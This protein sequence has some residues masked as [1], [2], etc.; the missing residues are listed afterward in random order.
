MAHHLASFRTGWE[1]ETLARY[2]LSRFSFVAHPASV[3][4]DIGTDFFC[5]L[6]ETRTHGRRR[7]LIPRNSFAIQIKSSSRRFDATNKYDYLVGLEM[8]FFVGAVDRRALRL[9]IYSGEYIPDLFS[10]KPPPNR[11][12]IEPC[13]SAVVDGVGAYFTD[14]GH[15]NYILKFPMVI[16]VSANATA[17]DVARIAPALHERCSVMRNNIASWHNDEYIF[18]H[19]HSGQI[20]TYAGCGSARVF[21]RNF[22]DR[23]AEVFA[24]LKWLYEKQPTSFSWEEFEV[25]EMLYCM[26]QQ[27]DNLPNHLA[28][29]FDA[30]NELVANDPYPQC[31]PDGEGGASVLL[32]PGERSKVRSYFALQPERRTQLVGCVREAWRR[33]KTDSDTGVGAGR[34]SSSGDVQ[35]PSQEG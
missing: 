23:L 1:N 34:R 12:K 22:Y 20:N 31:A 15:D 30:V 18:K 17:D 16:Q 9:D 14:E 2:L 8:P 4:D 21:R 29:L 11:L 3:S 10:Y 7:F 35:C 13:G 24:N 25:Y 33:A 28:W 32:A 19:P 26:L 5:T 27:Q 6:F